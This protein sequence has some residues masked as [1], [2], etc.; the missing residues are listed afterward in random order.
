MVRSSEMNDT[1]FV[2]E[3]IW[4]VSLK[5]TKIAMTKFE[6]KKMG[7]MRWQKSNTLSVSY[8]NILKHG[9]LES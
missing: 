9:S 8:S 2:D 7:Q 3:V 5:S 1:S 4:F 6:R